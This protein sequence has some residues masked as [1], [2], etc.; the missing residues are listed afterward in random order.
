MHTYLPC[1]IRCGCFGR[2]KGACD[3]WLRGA[4]DAVRQLSGTVNGPLL[5][6]LARRIGH[7]DIGC[8]DLFREGQHTF[9]CLCWSVF[10]SIVF[11]GAPLID[12]GAEW[13][14]GHCKASNEELFSQLRSDVNEEQLHQ[15]A[16]DDA[17]MHRMS[18]PVRAEPGIT[19]K[20]LCCPRFGVEQGVR[21]DGTLKLRAVD[22]FSWS[23]ANGLRKRKRR[24]VKWASINGHFTPGVEL[25]H[26]HLDDLLA[27]MKLQYVSTGQAC[28]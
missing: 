3:A 1:W 6:E 27:A 28:L 26:D 10:A 17:A 2:R 7:A 18:F 15:I 16:C 25:K 24:D 8:V 14:L 13:S 9:P 12:E 11:A 5:S 22:H 4:S 19:G 21:P 20:V 23:H